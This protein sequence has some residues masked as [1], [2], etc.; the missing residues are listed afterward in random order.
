MHATNLELC[1]TIP[2]VPPRSSSRP[3]NTDILT[4]NPLRPHVRHLGRRDESRH[5]RHRPSW[6]C[7]CGN[8]AWNRPSW[9]CA[10]P[11]DGTS[12]CRPSW[13]TPS[14]ATNVSWA[15]WCDRQIQRGCVQQ[16]RTTQGGTTTKDRLRFKRRATQINYKTVQTHFTYP[17]TPRHTGSRF[18]AM[19]TRYFT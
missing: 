13:P 17:R 8:G 4:D 14:C 18:R 10:W 5:R 12:S 9:R 3:P 2:C 6:T 19:T 1:P 7:A 15:P 16:L 11:T